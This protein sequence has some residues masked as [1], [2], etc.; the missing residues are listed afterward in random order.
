MEKATEEQ[1]RE[2]WELEKEVKLK[3]LAADAAKVADY[4]REE[5]AEEEARKLQQQGMKGK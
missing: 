5:G 4:E 1:A 3:R 2:C